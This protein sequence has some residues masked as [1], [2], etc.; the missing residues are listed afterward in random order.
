MNN[1]WKA[2]RGSHLFKWIVF[3]LLCLSLAGIVLSSA[4][5]VLF[6][7]FGISEGSGDYT[8]TAA[9]DSRLQEIAY[10]IEEQYDRGAI[11]NAKIE[12]SSAS[13]NVQ[14]A[15]K[16][17]LPGSGTFEL[18]SSNAV[19]TGYDLRKIYSFGVLQ[20]GYP[21]YSQYYYHGELSQMPREGYNGY[22]VTLY[23]QNGF[24]VKDEIRH[25]KE[26]YDT[27]R[28][29]GG[30]QSNALIA[31]IA[32]SVLFLIL[33]FAGCS[34]AGYRKGKEGI[35][36]QFPD[37]IPMDV[38]TLLCMFLGFCLIAIVNEGS[39][40]G[41]MEIKE[42][43]GVA[44]TFF[45]AAFVLSYVW[46]LSTARRC[47]AGTLV[48][49]N[50][51]VIFVT[52]I[53]KVLKEY[54]LP[55]KLAMLLLLGWIVLV[56]ILAGPNYLDAGEVFIFLIVS[57]VPAMLV[58]NIAASQHFLTKT[59]V[60]I[61]DGNLNSRVSDGIMKWMFG[62]CLAE[63]KALNSIGSGLEIAVERQIRSERMRTELITNVSHD[64][65]TPLT[66]IINYTDLLQK[67][68]TPEEEKE[69]LEAL[70][71]QSAR[72]KKLTEDIVEASRASSGNIN[73]ELTSVNV[74][75]L[76]DQSIGEY[77]E[78]LEAAKIEPIASIPRDLTV[79][80]DGRLLWRVFSNLLSN[81]C[82][83]AMP[84]TRVYFDAERSNGGRMKITV[85]NISREA[86]N[87]SADELMERFVRGDESRHSEGSGLGLSIAKSLTE[88][89]NGT[90]DV[91]IDGDLFRAEITLEEAA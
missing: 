51:I 82:K 26:L 39:S 8:E 55:M 19:G 36:L 76:V 17:Y 60:A 7:R 38:F 75:E 86:L 62:D 24:P 34:A 69:Y 80:A 73:A 85:K 47:K 37:H 87:I 22:Q 89:M 13:S 43:V 2:W 45:E 5:W 49:N 20:E 65:K 15:L 63:A 70:A 88:L 40:W 84:S 77:S 41:Q 46:L 72:L 14:F 91:V 35:T 16:R 59:A 79:K 90:F 53:T 64:I 52:Q 50:L 81:V 1:L 67:E 48:S 25:E 29:I 71:R 58:V 83:Y 42:A 23:V 44:I 33:L 78:K 74:K 68:H 6:E 27:L 18:V 4:C 28:N 11:E 54:S 9:F 3:I 61:A 32:C 21:N 56:P 10:D 30:G 12:Y 66:S 31:L 57:I